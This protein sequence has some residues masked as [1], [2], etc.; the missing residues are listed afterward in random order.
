MTNLKRVLTS[1][2]RRLIPKGYSTSHLFD[3]LSAGFTVALVALPLGLVVAIAAGARPETGLVGIIVGGAVIS[4]FTASRFQIGGPTDACILVAVAVIELYGYPGLLTTTMLA[5]LFLVAVAITRVG[6]L[7]ESMPQAVVSGFVSGMGAI[8]FF[9]QLVPFLGLGE[10]AHEHDH[11]GEEHSHSFIFILQSVFSRLGE[12]DTATL[13]VG[14]GS[15]TIVLVGR[16]LLPKFPAYGMALVG[17]AVATV[18]LDLPV[19]TI[20]SAFQSIPNTI[21]FPELP[22]F[23]AVGALLPYAVAVAFLT[24]SESLLATSMAVQARGR[25]AR[26]KANREFLALGLGNLATSFW[27]GFPVG[28]CVTRTATCLSAGARS[29]LAGLF[30]TAFVAVFVLAFAWALAYVPLTSLAAV[31]LLVSW[32]MIE[33]DRLRAVWRGPIGDKIT[34]AVIMATTLFWDIQWVIPVGILLAGVLFTRRVSRIFD[35]RRGNAALFDS[36][37]LVHTDPLPTEVPAGVEVL[38]FRGALFYG[39]V[40]SLYPLVSK[41]SEGRRACVFGMRNVYV[42]DPTSCLALSDL[43][44][45]LVGSGINCFFWGIQPEVAEV[46]TQAGIKPRKGVY[47]FPEAAGAIAAASRM[48]EQTGSAP[49]VEPQDH[50]AANQTKNDDPA[51]QQ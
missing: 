49:V 15:L 27:G 25:G 7:I 10:S 35:V 11:G 20:G 3:D 6:T 13:A 28:G 29:P 5:G 12:F 22:S 17:G 18:A 26:H 38:T 33:P 40:K 34:L 14:L 36:Q 8:I 23:A 4:A 30:H 19:A 32:E 37:E 9:G 45:K 47:F 48:A 1:E 2:F 46:M 24:S 39:T 16:R 21:P 51:T 43:L 50:E 44:D 31:L 42:M 41:A